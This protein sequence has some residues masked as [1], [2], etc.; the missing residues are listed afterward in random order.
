MHWI[1]QTNLFQEVGTQ[2]LIEVLCRERYTFSMHK[3]VPF[4]GEII[5]DIDPEG[6]VIVVGSYSMRHVAKRKEWKPGV[7]DMDHLTFEMMK[8][9][10]GENLLNYDGRVVKFGDL[11][12]GQLCA[13]W[14]PN[15]FF[16]RPEADTKYFAGTVI[17]IDDLEDWH[18]NILSLGHEQADLRLNINTPVIVASPKQIY[19]EHRFWVVD[20]VVVTNS[21][22]KAGNKVIHAPY[23]DLHIIDFAREMAKKFQPQRAFVLDVALT[24]DGCKIIEVNNIN[25]AG[26]YQANIDALVYA[27]VTMKD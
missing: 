5:P 20:G 23:T 19:Q 9:H 24:P 12:D 25:S 7:F 13:A 4:V 15:T 10:W 11:Y 3:V 2:R 14:L 17:S 22:Y 26:F 27:L 8:E 1:I 21:Q 16:I 6:P 18:K